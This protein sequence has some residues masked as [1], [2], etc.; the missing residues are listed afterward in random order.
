M[1]F[2]I[3]RKNKLITLVILNIF[4]II[5]YYTSI[6]LYG[7]WTDFFFLILTVIFILKYSKEIK[8]NIFRRF[9]KIICIINIVFSVFTSFSF[10]HV[11]LPVHHIPK[12]FYYDKEEY[13]YYLERGNYG[14][15]SSCFGEV[16]YFKQIPYLPFLEIKIDTDKCCWIDYKGYINR[17]Y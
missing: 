13:A 5:S 8:N 4:A 10:Y 7:Y 3:S 12:G 11:I 16:Q 14:L 9:I 1:K 2:D 6:S 17:D 15:L